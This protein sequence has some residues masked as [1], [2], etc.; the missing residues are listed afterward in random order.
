LRF[1]DV[2]DL[3]RLA[4][5]DPSGRLEK[6]HVVLA[7]DTEG[8]QV[9]AADA[10]LR[11]LK[12][13]AAGVIPGVKGLDAS[14]EWADGQGALMLES[15]ALRVAM[16]TLF[17]EEFLFDR[18]QARLLL[19]RGRGGVAPGGARSFP[20]KPGCR[21]GRPRDDRTR[22]GA[23]PGP[24]IAVPACRRTAGGP[25]PAGAQVPRADLPLA[26]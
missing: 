9:Q 20:G 17:P 25:L 22:R 10:Q 23:S 2:P 21:A 7:R 18:L 15:N 26:G 12:L 11:N 3:A 14:L 8:W 19:R 1:R 6:L 16:P 4:P 13:H 24:G 5:S